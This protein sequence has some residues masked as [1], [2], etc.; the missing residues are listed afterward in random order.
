VSSPRRKTGFALVEV[1]VA[2]AI[3]GLVIATSLTV[4]FGRQK[5]LKQAADTIAAYQAL[6]NEAEVQRHLSY[7]SLES[8]GYF[9]SLIDSTG[10]ERLGALDQLKNVTVATEVEVLTP[11]V[12]EVRMSVLWGEKREHSARM[13]IIR[14]PAGGMG[15]GM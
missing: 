4:F 2:V 13:S 3:L 5:R 10:N 7:E 14:T 12:K 11:V 8:A 6:A 15:S 1:L 9:Q